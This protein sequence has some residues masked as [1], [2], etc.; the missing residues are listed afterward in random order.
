MPED[1]PERLFTE[2]C[3]HGL[4]ARLCDDVDSL[5]GFLPPQTA[6]LV[7]RVADVLEVLQP[8]TA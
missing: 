2:A 5:A 4:K 8:A 6:A 1:A 7:R 3:L